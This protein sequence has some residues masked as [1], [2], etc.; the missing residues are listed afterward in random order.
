M[1]KNKTLYSDKEGKYSATLEPGKYTVKVTVRGYE[2]SVKYVDVSDFNVYPKLV[3][4]TLAKDRNV[5][6]MPR[7]VFV[8]LTGILVV[9]EEFNNCFDVIFIVKVAQFWV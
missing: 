6:G 3:I 9:K 5:W 4:F 1:E 2:S 7:L 8:I